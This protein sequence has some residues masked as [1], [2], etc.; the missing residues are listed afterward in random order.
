MQCCKETQT[1]QQFDNYQSLLVDAFGTFA[2]PQRRMLVDLMRS[3]LCDRGIYHMQFARLA[4]VR[5]TFDAGVASDACVEDV[6]D[7][8]NELAGNGFA[9]ILQILADESCKQKR[10]SLID[11]L[12][13]IKQQHASAQ[14]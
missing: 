9:D 3:R 2:C 10:R 6:A 8:L 5:H 13:Y 14:C 11:E 12:L 1:L 7:L 4:D